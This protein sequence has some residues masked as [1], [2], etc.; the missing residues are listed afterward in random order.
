MTEKE[1]QKFIGTRLDELRWAKS[2][3]QNLFDNAL[4][5]LDPIDE[6]I[7]HLSNIP[8]SGSTI[9]GYEIKGLILPVHNIRHINPQGL[10]MVRLVI[11]MSFTADASLWD[12]MNDPFL[13]YSFSMT[14]FGEMEGNKYSLC[15]HLDKDE[16]PNSE[17][18]H[19]LYH[20]HY[21]NG[22]EH[23][24]VRD[25]EYDWGS[26][27]YLDVPRFMHYPVDLILGIGLCLTNF[28]SKKIF[29][30]LIKEVGFVR[31]Y[32][33]AQNNIMQPYYLNLVSQWDK[34]NRNIKWKTPSKLCPQL[35]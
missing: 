16:A 1:F 29:E 31:A 17:E 33:E 14:L 28:H 23:L 18:F 19:P 15:W 21:S 24:P 27:I 11:D 5:R 22:K 4:L 30:S 10:N 2:T 34:N 12:G 7:K 13:T 32:K 6:V 35:V 20:I 9:W 26:V 3:I 8:T 25:H